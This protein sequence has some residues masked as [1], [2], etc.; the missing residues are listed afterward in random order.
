MDD[1]DLYPDEIDQYP[2]DMGRTSQYAGSSQQPTILPPG[3]YSRS[4]TPLPNYSGLRGSQRGM[5]VQGSNYG[6]SYDMEQEYDEPYV[7]RNPSF[8]APMTP[9]SHHLPSNRNSL[10]APGSLGRSYSQPMAS[11]H[12]SMAGR[13]SPSP[14]LRNP[15]MTNLGGMYDDMPPLQEYYPTSRHST[16]HLPPRRSRT[17]SVGHTQYPSY[18]MQQYNPTNINRVHVPYNSMAS[19]SNYN[20]YNN[21][22]TYD[23]DYNSGRRSSRHGHR[24][25]SHS[26][27]SSESDSD[28]SSSWS[29]STFSSSSSSGHYRPSGYQTG[30]GNVQQHGYY[31]PTTVIQPS[32]RHQPLVVPINGGSGGYVIVPAAGQTVKV[33]DPK[34]PYKDLSILD[35]IFSPSTWNIGSKKS[36]SRV[37]RV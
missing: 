34:R 10:I 2:S 16:T 13:M 17:L 12:G 5:S 36:G 35:R 22:D 20:N 19:R 9:M 1:Y 24:Y 30:Y 29:D 14:I 4:G 25:S 7:S 37:I 33:V 11:R 32:S 31:N 3:S 26:G 15:S 18:D 28:T 21:Y 27:Y 8:H 23:Y 6:R